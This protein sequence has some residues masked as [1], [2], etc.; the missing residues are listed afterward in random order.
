MTEVDPK[1]VA[2]I[3]TIGASVRRMREAKG[4]SQE[5]LTDMAGFARG[6]VG[7]LERG[8]RSTGLMVLIEV[9]NALEVNIWQL[10]GGAKSTH[11]KRPIEHEVLHAMLDEVYDSKNEGSI[12]LVR[13]LL[14]QITG[15]RRK[16]PSS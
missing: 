5:G 7:D 15:R 6:T 4:L 9:L 1:T 3:Q 13:S 12:G 16:T 2:W 11:P 8:A 14:E 10:F